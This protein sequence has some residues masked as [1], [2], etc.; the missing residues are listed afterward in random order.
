MVSMQWRSV[1]GK[2]N[3][4]L[5]ELAVKQVYCWIFDNSNNVIIVSKNGDRWQLPGGKPEQG[6][7]LKSALTREVYE[8]TGIK[9]EDKSNNPKI[10]GYY[11]VT[12]DP[13][14]KNEA[15]LQLRYYVQ[16]DRKLN[17]LMPGIDSDKEDI[18]YAKAVD[19]KE[20]LR[21]IQWMANSGE[22]RT[23]VKV[24]VIE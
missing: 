9:I 21:T 8:E 7:L 24:G 10:F 15:Y 14:S 5:P 18:K 17:N 1:I 13:S 20:L 23:L 12:G 11:I 4:E 6:E 16:M 2:G 19:V 22:Y 3:Y